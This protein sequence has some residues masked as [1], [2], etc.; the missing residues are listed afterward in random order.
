MNTNNTNTEINNTI[1]ERLTKLAY[2]KSRPFCY[3]CYHE[4]P[5]T[6]CPK[7][8]SDDN[9]RIVN[10]VGVEFG[11][12]W[13]IEH[14]IEQTLTPINIDEDFE[15]LIEEIYPPVSAGWLSLDV[16]RVSAFVRDVQGSVL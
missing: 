12:S 8:G 2:A 1:Q 10:G 16:V 6:G 13:I 14:L 9:M 11:C 7:C 4:V 15:N 5:D 3:T